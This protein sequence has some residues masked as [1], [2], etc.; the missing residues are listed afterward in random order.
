MK[1]NEYNLAFAFEEVAS[2]LEGSQLSSSAFVDAD[3]AIAYIA[4]KLRITKD[5]V[6]ILSVMFYYIGQTIEIKDLGTFANTPVVRVLSFQQDFDILVRKGMI[7]QLNTK[8]YD[9][10]TQKYSLSLGMINA[11]KYNKRFKP[12]NYSSLQLMEVVDIISKAINDCDYEVM[13]YPQM[14]ELFEKLIADTQ[15]LQFSQKLRLYGFSNFNLSLL[16]IGVTNLLCKGKPLIEE[17]DYEDIIPKVYQR[18]IFNQFKQK[19][20]ELMA[21]NLLEA[22]DDSFE[23]Y[24][25]TENA[26]DSLLEGCCLDYILEDVDEIHEAKDTDSDEPD[27]EQVAPKRMFYNPEEREQVQRLTQ[28]LDQDKFCEVQERMRKVGMRPGF[29]CLFYGGPGTG[30]SETVLQLARKTGR[31]VIHVNVSTLRD[32]YVGESEK[33][34]QK[35]FDDYKSKL[36]DSIPAPILFFNEADAIFGKRFTEVSD[37]VNKMENTI[38]NIILQNMETFEGILIAT[39]NLTANF[40]KAFERRFLYKIEFKKPEASVRKQIWKSVMPELAEDDA[41]RLADSY[42]FS[43]AQIENVAKRMTIDE[44]LYDHCVSFDLI[45]QM[46]EEERIKNRKTKYNI[47]QQ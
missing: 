3:N 34:I 41:E 40:D 46:C 16:L 30:K 42:S 10:E 36:N 24:R 7:K 20:S 15:H 28:L 23:T 22:V 45:C 2:K 38:Q 31:E 47:M 43:G 27:I 33:N 4:D 26:K 25:L 44:I 1:S 19:S 13:T 35:V 17:Y 29:T 39:T 6:F 8:G 18:Q 9:Y 11:V 14:V 21:H 32:Y 5:Q 37:A 12:I